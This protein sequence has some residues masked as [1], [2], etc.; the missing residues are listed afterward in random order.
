MC[1]PSS[2]VKGNGIKTPKVR[3]KTGCAYLKNKKPTPKS[4]EKCYSM[5]IRAG[6]L[7]CKNCNSTYPILKGIPRMLSPDKLEG[8]LKSA[9]RTQSHWEKWWSSLRTEEDIALYDRLW[10]EAEREL[11]AKPLFEK[12]DFYGKVV[13]DAGCGGGRHLDWFHDQGALDVIGLDLGSQVELARKR[14][15]DLPNVHLVQGNLVNAPIR[16]GSLDTIT[17]HGVLHHTPIPKKSFLSLSKK[18]KTGGTFALWVYHKEWAHHTFH[19]KGVAGDFVVSAGVAL[20]RLIRKITSY[21]PHA[22]LI[23]FCYLLSVK[24]SIEHSLLKKSRSS[25]VRTIGGTSQ[26]IPPISMIGVNFNERLVRNYDHYSATYN[27]AFTTEEILSWFRDAGFNNLDVVSVPVGV[28]GIKVKNEAE[29]LK[30]KFYK[31]V[32]H[33]K[34]REKWDEA[35]KKC[36]IPA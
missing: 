20:W 14:C 21:F 22:L 28:K 27:Y 9:K 3:C 15:R 19:N 8:Q 4:C 7:S 29:P 25:P 36:H 11:K 31:V 35:Y 16:N 32:P 5:E 2:Q 12:K 6:R 26:K 34:F 24:G 1:K 23:V 13:L 10:N 33:F 30:V 17:S 18:I